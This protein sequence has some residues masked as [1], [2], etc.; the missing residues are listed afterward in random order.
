MEG[1]DLKHFPSRVVKA[2]VAHTVLGTEE[3]TQLDKRSF[4]FF[5]LSLTSA[6]VLPS[7]LFFVSP[8]R[9]TVQEAPR[10]FFVCGMRWYDTSGPQIRTKWI[11]IFSDKAAAVAISWLHFGLI[12]SED[13][14][15][16]LCGSQ[17]FFSFSEPSWRSSW[18][19]SSK[20]PLDNS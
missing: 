2:E 20:T 12:R 5:F 18:G 4:F 8:P 15:L 16:F 17:T 14:S 7:F 11:C 13:G 10:A 19:S 6:S 9:S 3:H 1:T